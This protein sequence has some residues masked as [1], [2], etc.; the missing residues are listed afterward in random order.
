[1]RKLLFIVAIIA[2]MFTA[3]STD[4]DAEVKPEAKLNKVTFNTN[5]LTSE[6]SDT[7]TEIVL[8]VYDYLL[9]KQDGTFVK[10]IQFTT[11]T[12]ADELPEGDYTVTLI[13]SDRVGTSNMI[14]D[15]DYVSCSWSM[16]NAYT[17]YTG[18]FKGKT[19]FTITDNEITAVNI[20][21]KRISGALAFNFTDIP[22][23]RQ[24]NVEIQNMPDQYWMGER[25]ADGSARFGSSPRSNVITQ[26]LSPNLVNNSPY[27]ATVKI[28][29]YTEDSVVE[30]IRTI[31]D[32]P[33]APNCTTTISGEILKDETTTKNSPFNI[34]IDETWGNPIT[35]NI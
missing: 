17:T 30:K 4:K 7:K 9:F 25:G 19:D 16:G 18:I 22:N 27:L 11:E 33:L 15:N 31:N 26:F 10:T 8:P 24:L 20:N 32:V 34:T 12:V 5:N 6:V 13:G 35:I 1:M 2:T 29:V 21:L 3:C 28:T 23:G 14:T